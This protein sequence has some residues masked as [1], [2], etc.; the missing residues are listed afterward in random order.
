MRVRINWPVPAVALLDAVTSAVGGDPA[1][2]RRD[3][4][5]PCD[6]FGMHR[7]GN[8]PDQ[9]LGAL[10]WVL[11]AEEPDRGWPDEPDP[12][13]LVMLVVNT[14]GELHPLWD[15]LQ[16]LHETNV[17]PVVRDWLDDRRVPRTAW[18]WC[19]EDLGYF[20]GTLDVAAL[21]RPDDLR[22]LPPDA[23]WSPDNT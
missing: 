6:I 19:C 22:A 11:W 7:V 18:W 8:Q 4:A 10:V 16:R 3:E 23:R 1:T 13:A 12:P 9:G 15:D 5:H 17:L 21:T 20:P 2:V 14:A